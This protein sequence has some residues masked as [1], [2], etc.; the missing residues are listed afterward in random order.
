MQL[1]SF[2]ASDL[3]IEMMLSVA[4]LPS[5]TVPVLRKLVAVSMVFAG[6]WKAM[7]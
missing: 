4:S 5:D 1:M 3:C 7:L 2:L 6:P